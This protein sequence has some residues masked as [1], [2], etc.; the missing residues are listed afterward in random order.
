MKKILYLHGKGSKPGGTKPEYLKSLGYEV[1]NPHLP[2]ESFSESVDIAKDL[3]K[4]HKPDIV[5][6]SS[7]GGA[8]ALAASSSKTK[9]K[10]ILICPAW[11]RFGVTPPASLESATILHAA[12]DSIVSHQDSEILSEI[13]HA[14]LITCGTNHRMIDKEALNTLEGVLLN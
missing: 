14:K 8:V 9:L 3:I 7:R 10:M 12:S 6:A 4:N 2:D 5:V 13:L 1:I 11:K